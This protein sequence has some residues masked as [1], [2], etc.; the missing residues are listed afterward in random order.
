MARKPEVSH[1]PALG[2]GQRVLLYDACCLQQPIHCR[3]TCGSQPACPTP[4]IHPR[5]CSRFSAVCL[6]G[7]QGERAHRSTIHD[8]R[9]RAARSCDVSALTRGLTAV[10]RVISATIRFSIVHIHNIHDV[11]CAPT[12]SPRPARP[13]WTSLRHAPCDHST[14]RGGRGAGRAHG[15]GAPGRVTGRAR[16][17][18]TRTD[19]RIESNMSSPSRVSRRPRPRTHEH[20]P[21]RKARDAAVDATNRRGDYDLRMWNVAARAR[22]AHPT[23]TTHAR[24][25][26]QLS[27]ARHTTLPHDTRV[28]VT[29]PQCMHVSTRTSRT[30]T[31]PPPG[32]STERTPAGTGFCAFLGAT[33][34]FCA[35]VN[36]AQ[37]VLQGNAAA[38]RRP[39]RPLGAQ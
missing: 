38:C 18:T 17:A 14:T 29:P 28:D 1:E 30:Q 37:R 7:R 23:S 19:N 32:A 36:A 26:R 25:S 15:A 22:H 10:L 4:V 13:L 35:K 24:E 20:T 12:A 8:G 33:A 3:Q 16:D 21:A 9:R 39:P 27:T 6:N 2:H 34:H 31:H 11:Q 5:D